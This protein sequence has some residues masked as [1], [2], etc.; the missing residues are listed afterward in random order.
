MRR[1]AL[2]LLA[3]ITFIIW[4]SATAEAI[5]AWG[6]KYNVECS[7]CHAGPMYKLS[8]MGAEFL[9]RGH[10]MAEDETVTDLAKL[11]SVNTKIRFND[12]NAAGRN[13]SFE[14]HAFSLYTGGMLSKHVSYFT[15]FYMYENTGRT[16]GSI[17][18]DL[19]RSKLADAYILINSNPEKATYTT[20]RVGQISPTQM[21]LYWN[22]GPRYTETR[23]YIVNN[24]QVGPNTYRPFMRNFGAEVAQTVKNF[25]A[26]A[27][28]LNGTGASVTNSIDNNESKDVYGTADYVLD[29]QGSAV[30]FYGYRGKGL[31]TPSTGSTWE[32]KFHRLGA[33]GQYVRGPATVT[34]AITQGREQITG[35]GAETDN[36]GYLLEGD[37]ELNDKIALF[38]RYDYFDGNTDVSKDHIRGPVFGATYRFFELGR[39]VFEYHK[40]GKSPASGASVP[41]E[42]RC[43]LAFTF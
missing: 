4:P 11:I 30:G 6:R 43:E 38:G 1:I 34:A 21:L 20:F 37:Y 3:G 23:P 17:N 18:S 31:V 39:T 24:S 13:S 19:G 28:V 29:N 41:W 14:L 32:N 40:Q 9:R 33:F 22:V 35:A 36:R 5:P 25:H 7:L 27:G 12:S 15:E 26:A 42:Y 8:P 16:T 2:F 10:R